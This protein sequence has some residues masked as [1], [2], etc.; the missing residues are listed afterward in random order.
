MREYQ[1]SITVWSPLKIIIWEMRHEKRPNGLALSLSIRVFRHG[2]AAPISEDLPSV[3]LRISFSIRKVSEICEAQRDAGRCRVPYHALMWTWNITRQ[4]WKVISGKA[5]AK[6]IWL[7]FRIPAL[8][9][10]AFGFVICF[11][12]ISPGL[13]SPFPDGLLPKKHGRLETHLITSCL[14]SNKVSSPE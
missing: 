5:R 14:T 11:V 12:I 2:R 8:E 13:S 6:K 4:T 1:N 3:A 9:D 10:P 7:P